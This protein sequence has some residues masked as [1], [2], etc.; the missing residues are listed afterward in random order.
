MS[1]DHIITTTEDLVRFRT[2]KDRPKEM[3]AC[4]EYIEKFFDG[5]GLTVERLLHNGVESVVV[6]KGIK[7]P[8]VFLTGHFDVV[9]GNDD[10]FEPHIVED[11]LY[12]RG[13]VDMKAAAAIMMHIM[14]ES[15]RTD[16]N[17]GLML[18]GDEEIGGFDG[19]DHLLEQGHSCEVAVIPDGGFDV[20]QVVTKAKGII[21]LK[22]SSYGKAVHGSTPWEGDNAILK[23]RGVIST[24]AEMFQEANSSG[25]AWE[26]TCSINR[27][28]GGHANNQV[29]DAVDIFCDIRFTEKD[30]PKELVSRIMKALPEHAIVTEISNEPMTYVDE[31]HPHVQS[32]FD[33]LRQHGHTPTPVV[34]HGSTDGRFFSTRDIP[35]IISQPQGGNHHGLNE[36]VSVASMKEYYAI[37]SSYVESI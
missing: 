33:A 27:I 21:W 10:Q 4:A 1:F 8:K 12:A 5:T 17:V 32:F 34:E 28:E 25:N 37:L 29:P 11:K 35:V 14:K 20:H 19:V 36:W 31:N 7:N 22:I 15:A 13:A 26:T 9:E 6:T 23:I 3:D 30:D 16:A 2:T 24:L 18:T